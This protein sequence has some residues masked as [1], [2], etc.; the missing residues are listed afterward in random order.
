MYRDLD[1]VERVR[2]GEGERLI[3][4]VRIAQVSD[5]DVA[6]DVVSGVELQRRSL[7]DDFVHRGDLCRRCTRIIDFVVHVGRAR[8]RVVIHQP[9]RGSHRGGI[10]S[11]LRLGSGAVHRRNVDRQ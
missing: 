11:R 6:A 10:G 7:V 5:H 2:V 4:V 8:Q 9:P 3:R 1:R